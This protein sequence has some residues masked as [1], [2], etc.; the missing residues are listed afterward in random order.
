MPDLSLVGL[1]IDDAKRIKWDRG[2]E[3]YGSVF[4]GDPL[5]ELY[6]ELIDGMNYA[7]EAL[8][9]GLMS[10]AEWAFIVVRL[11][12]SAFTVRSICAARVAAQAGEK[13]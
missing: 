11:T 5:G 4:V 12:G 13:A 9:Q 10:R 7:D 6:D 1:T 3:R 8:R 2:Q